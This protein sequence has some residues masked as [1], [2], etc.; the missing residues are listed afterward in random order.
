MRGYIIR[1]TL[2]I[3]KTEFWEGRRWYW[4]A[5]LDKFHRGSS[6]WVGGWRVDRVPL[7]RD[8]KRRHYR[9]TDSLDQRNKPGGWKKHCLDTEIHWD[10][11][12]KDVSISKYQNLMEPVD[13]GLNPKVSWGYWR[14]LNKKQQMKACFRALLHKMWSGDDQH[15][16]Y[17]TWEVF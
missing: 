7:G 3:T 15:Q 4:Q 1:A 11:G 17:P 6:S 8:Q 14:F 2:R 16:L 13:S 12:G 5:S 10:P 9:Q